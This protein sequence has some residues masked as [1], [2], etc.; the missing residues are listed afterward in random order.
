M[1]LF[2]VDTETTDLDPS[3]GGTIIE[4]A[5]ITLDQSG[6]GWYPL[7]Y[8]TSYIEYSGPMNPHARASHHI[9]DSRL[10]KESGAIPRADAIKWLRD[11]VEADSIFVAHNVAFDSKFLPELS[12]YRPWIC[13]YRSA[14][15]IWP[16]APG[17]S[18]QVLRYWMQLEIRDDIL[19]IAP[20]LRHMYPHQALFDVAITTGILLKMLERYSTDQLLH[21]SRSPMTL[22]KIGFGKHKGTEFDRI[23]KDY[24]QW[25]RGQSNLD[26]DLRHTIEVYLRK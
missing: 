16:E 4:L 20:I 5:W 19:E 24:L 21:M 2:V 8:S 6:N 10:T 9:P 11:H 18:N 13:T 14:K 3:T 26:E 1:K 17:H 23:P 15:H 25:L 7:S 22:K 12:I